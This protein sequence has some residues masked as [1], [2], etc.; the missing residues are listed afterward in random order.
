[1]KVY[2]DLDQF[3]EVVNPV[4]TIGTFDGVHIGHR[5]IIQRIKE[6]AKKVN[7][8]TVLLTFFPHPRMILH[9]EDNKVKLIT[10][11]E[12]KIE[13]LARESIDHL[14]IHPFT[15]E[16][17]NLS[18]IEFIRNILVEKIGTK[19]LVIGYNHH[20]G[21]NREGS[22]KHL[23]EFSDV[24]G[25]EVEEIPAQDIDNV[26]ISSTKIR[27]ALLEGDVE[28]ANLY[29]GH[30]Y[31]LRGEVVEGDKI[32]REIGFPTANIQVK[33]RYKLIPANG[34]YAVDVVCNG[35]KHKG[36]L[37]IGNRPTVN[38]NRNAIEV[39]IFNFDKNI[40]GKEIG[41]FFKKRIRDEKKFDNLEELK[42]Q[43]IKDKQKAITI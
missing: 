28:T 33:D 6:V 35:E 13:L 10:S 24:Y 9:P 7:G 39:N 21:K 20:F 11:Q 18:S 8:E 29:L 31:Q 2:T 27:N 30:S 42:N 32:G 3:K 38:N 22:F 1:M 26:S 16:F 40:Y 14:I 23:K 15:P 19:K 37:N 34:V 4:V 36:M 43:L 25:F 5:K 41:V 17:S 12:E